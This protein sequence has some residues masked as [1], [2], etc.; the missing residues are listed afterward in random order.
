MNA[1][2]KII[3]F[4]LSVMLT[5]SIV[6]AQTSWSGVYV[7]PE[8]SQRKLDADWSTT[9]TYFPDG[10][11][12]PFLISPDESYS[13]STIELGGYVGYNW[14]INPSWVAGVELNLGLG[15]N[16]DE[17]NR[18]PGLFTGSAN[19]TTVT[20][21]KNASILGRGGFKITPTM[22]VYITGG[23]AFQ[24]FEV[25]STCNADTVV[26]NPALG[27]QTNSESTTLTG[28][29]LG[30]GYEI[31]LWSNWI[32]RLEY[33]YADYGEYDFTALPAINGASFG[34]D[35]TVDVTTQTASVGM[36]YKF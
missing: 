29:T 15:E 21:G 12:I 17:A 20:A 10:T 31:Q 26:C 34:A 13:D 8:I 23:L 18:I 4:I 32:G 1:K 33:S 28:F 7:G 19:F 2:V 35:A 25:E 22:M 30:I 14:E 16:E 36:A 6:N 27:V 24:E 3:C 9:A 5:P 11:V